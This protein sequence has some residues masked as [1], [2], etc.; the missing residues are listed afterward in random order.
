M[1]ETDAAVLGLA[2]NDHDGPVGAP[3]I[4]G[5]IACF[6]DAGNLI[7]YGRETVAQGQLAPGGF[8]AFEFAVPSAISDLQAET[9]PFFLVAVN[10]WATG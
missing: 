9:R 1:D 10:A 7:D 2:T 3:T 4:N 5:S 6:D 8:A